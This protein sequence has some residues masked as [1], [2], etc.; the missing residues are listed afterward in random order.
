MPDKAHE[1]VR[2]LIRARQSAVEDLR[3]R[4]Q[5]ISSMMLRHGW[6]FAGKK[7]WGALH[8]HWLRA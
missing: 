7:T 4:R 8:G 5:A 3:R 1:T 2:A 6:V